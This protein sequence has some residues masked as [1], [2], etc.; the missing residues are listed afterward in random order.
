M[1]Q[2]ED[3]YG[4]I[5]ENLKY[6]FIAVVKSKAFMDI[7]LSGKIMLGVNLFY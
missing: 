1:I 7:I 2:S 5:G 6:S 3:E 4:F